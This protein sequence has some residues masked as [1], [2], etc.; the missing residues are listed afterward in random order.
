MYCIVMNCIHT[1]LLCLFIRRS[2]QPSSTQPPTFNEGFRI[3]VRISQS[4]QQYSL[5]NFIRLIPG[6]EAISCYHGNLCIDTLPNR[7][8]PISRMLIS[9]INLNFFFNLLV[10]IG[11]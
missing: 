9:K 3:N 7:T 4:I 11:I 8:K 5:N 1:A 10:N 2:A 6:S